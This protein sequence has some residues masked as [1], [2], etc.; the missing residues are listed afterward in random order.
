MS[1]SHHSL[2]LWLPSFELRLELARTPEL[3]GTSVG[4][5]APPDLGGTPVL[6]QLSERAGRAGLEPGMLVSK[7]IALCPS[8]TILEPD[9]AHY[10]AA[11]EGMLEALSQIS[12]ILE[13][14]H[15]GLVHVGVDGLD[16]LFGHAS[17]Q[18]ERV[19]QVLLEVLPPPLVAGF[20]MGYAP[21]TFGARV[22]A[23]AARPG[24]PIFVSDKGGSDRAVGPNA[25]RDFLRPQPLQFAPLPASGLERLRRLGLQTLG[26]IGDLPR[27]AL[28]R[29]FG[30]AGAAAQDCIRGEQIDPVQAVHQPR[31]LRTRMDFSAPTGNKETLVRALERLIDRLL[32]HPERKDRSLREVQLGGMLEGGGSWQIDGILREPTAQREPLVFLLRSRLDLY[33]PPRALETLH[34]EARTFGAPVTQIG[35]FARNET[36]ARAQEGNPSRGGSIGESD[37][38]PP[39]L[40]EAV[41][42]LRLR[43]GGDP[44]FRVVEVDPDSRIPERRYA[45]FPVV[46]ASDTVP[47]ATVPQS[48]GPGATGPRAKLPS[49]C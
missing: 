18:I 48:T 5:L 32:Q 23:A 45:L 33:P 9:P 3:D 24:S 19:L 35:L 28:I 39:S 43:I 16:R 29:Q 4:L 44:L 11:M 40:R 21:G 6:T 36:G 34:V 1:L 7:A 10:E 12:P 47:N 31:P 2:C 20:R 13:P 26:E 38:M 42:Q 30:R 49:S 46:S 27:T 15:P 22:A 25:L 14:V 17:Q 8:L 41:R 37:R